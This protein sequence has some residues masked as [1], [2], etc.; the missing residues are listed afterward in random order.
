MLTKSQRYG[1]GQLQIFQNSF[2]SIRLG[3]GGTKGMDDQ[4]HGCHS[5][6][7]YSIMLKLCDF[8]FL[9]LRHLLTKFLGKLINQ[10]G[11]LLLFSHQDE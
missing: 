6:N 8:Q 1:R 4:I 3:G 9:S 2:T 5:G 7:N 11:L 10:G